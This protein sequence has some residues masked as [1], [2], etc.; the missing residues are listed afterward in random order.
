MAGDPNLSTTTEALKVLDSYESDT[1]KLGMPHSDLWLMVWLSMY[2]SCLLCLLNLMFGLLLMTCLFVHAAATC[3][4]ARWTN[5][6]A[7]ISMLKEV[8]PV[9]HAIFCHHQIKIQ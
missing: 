8:G 4:L 3:S 6:N 1:I 5:H 2:Y 9:Y 7:L